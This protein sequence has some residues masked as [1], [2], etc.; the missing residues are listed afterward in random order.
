VLG[1]IRALL[2]VLLPALSDGLDQWAD[3]LVR[4][5]YL[6]RS[7]EEIEEMHEALARTRDRV[8]DLAALAEGDTVLDVGA[9]TGLL[10]FG[11]RERVGESG[12]VIALDVSVDALYELLRE[13]HEL[14]TAG[15]ALQIGEAETLPLPDA[16]V[17]VV[18]ARSVLIYV[19]EKRRAA[20]E[21]LRVLRPGGR[22]SIFE[23]L[24][25]RNAPL[26]ELVQLAELAPLAEGR[27]R[28]RLEADDP[29]LDFDAADLEEIFTA[30]GFAEV[31]GEVVPHAQTLSPE[32][33]LTTPGA[34][35]RASLF[36]QW[37][38]EH[39]DA[40]ADRFS[41]LVHAHGPLEVTVQGLHLA[42]RKP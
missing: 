15:I 37:R 29:M 14:Q 8:L 27:Q 13:A 2:P 16:C 10:T 30:A 24:N 7:P 11:A 5:R 40:S 6:S 23:P 36:E 17:D 38:A 35:G 20:K 42:A 25:R 3:W 18:V 33:F 19:R 31:R 28:R 39:G 26:A 32:A 12:Q 21:F 1:G 22:V 41:E 34:P 4:E 9:G